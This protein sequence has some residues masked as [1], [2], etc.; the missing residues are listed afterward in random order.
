MSQ[1]RVHKAVV[2]AAGLGTRLFPITY[3]IP[4]E[5]LP[6]GTFPIIHYLFSELILSGIETVIM[7]LREGNLSPLHYFTPNPTLDEKAKGTELEPLLEPL[8]KLREKLDVIT[9]FQKSPKG[10]GDAIRTAHKIVGNDPFYVC[11]PD[12]III[13]SPPILVELNEKFK[14]TGYGAVA[15]MEV[16]EE[17]V[18]RYGIVEEKNGKIVRVVEKPS[19]SETTSRLA[20]VGRYLFPPGFMENLHHLKPGKNNEYQL[21]DAMA[22]HLKKSPLLAVPIQGIRLDT[23]TREGYIHAWET[24]LKKRELFTSFF[25]FLPPSPIFS[26]L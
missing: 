16:L 24:F 19:P 14:D 8:W 13:Q 1:N 2:P 11:L 21:T 3:A 15:V 6:L 22:L 25:S 20:I 5:F 12:E 4:K 23:G 7:V 9:V 17:E 18:S 26:P 10:L